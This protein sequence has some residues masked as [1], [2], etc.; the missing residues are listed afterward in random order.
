MDRIA[1]RYAKAVFELAVE[2]RDVEAIE[3]DFRSIS[4]MLDQEDAFKAFLENP[5]I[6]EHKKYGI[7]KEMFKDRLEPLTYNFLLLVTEKKRIDLLP[8]IIDVFYRLVLNYRNTVEG[9][10]VSAV[11]LNETQVGK[12][13][14]N[15]ETMIGK[16]VLLKEDVDTSII[17]GFVVRV[18]DLVID[19][20]IRYQLEKLREKLVAE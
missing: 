8:A 16:S 5:L 13:K 17:G 18:E 1:K 15:I 2:N 14:T 4:A 7:V 3:T 9:E 20:S 19:N 6:N 11:A 10:L 12:I